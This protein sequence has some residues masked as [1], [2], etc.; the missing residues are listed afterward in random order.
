MG[1]INPGKKRFQFTSKHWAKLLKAH[2]DK[3]VDN[4][5][6]GILTL[7][8]GIQSFRRML[9]SRDR[10]PTNPDIESVQPKPVKNKRGPRPNVEVQELL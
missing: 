7:R 5:D 2:N 10:L 6:E 9:E 4:I 8:S 3:A 1:K